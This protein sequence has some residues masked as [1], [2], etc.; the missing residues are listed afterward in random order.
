M[1]ASLLLSLGLLLAILGPQD[2]C[3][4][5]PCGGSASCVN[6]LSERFCMCS[7][8]Y[9][10][11]EPSCVK[12][13][14]FPGEI[15]VRVT[16]TTGLDNKTSPAYQDLYRKVVKF[17]GNAL[18]KA[19]YGFGQTIIIKVSVSSSQSTRS[20]MRAASETTVSVSVVNMFNESTIVNEST[21]TT[22]IQE[23][24]K[25]VNSNMEFYNEQNLCDYYGCEQNAKDN[26]QD[27]LQC[28]CRS[29]MSRPSPLVPFCTTGVPLAIVART[30]KT[31]A[32]GHFSGAALP[33]TDPGKA[34]KTGVRVKSGAVL[35]GP[36]IH[37]MMQFPQGL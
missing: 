3:K 30:A 10:Y 25:K 26:C 6:L 22:T 8:G 4:L 37:S 17:F 14:T 36:G 9:Y 32:N 29:G 18:N 21:I 11:E 19:D 12:G 5:K 33:K 28:K 35:N 16:E 24:V 34:I 27:P 1:K 20:A 31:A 13:K 15:G 7:E 2:H 23:E